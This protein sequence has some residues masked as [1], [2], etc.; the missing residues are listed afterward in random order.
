M[1]DASSCSVSRS[2]KFGRKAREG[3]VGSGCRLEVRG[4]PIPN[5]PYGFCGRSTMKEVDGF[6]AIEWAI[7]EQFRHYLLGGKFKVI[8]DNNP[9][10]YFR[11]AKL[12]VLE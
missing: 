8:T 12:G 9:L 3:G 4:F 1:T 11:S 6:L 10:T 5:R 7:T 2:A